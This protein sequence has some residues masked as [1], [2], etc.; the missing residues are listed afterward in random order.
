MRS[1]ISFPGKTGLGVFLWCFFFFTPAIVFS[2]SVIRGTI[3][4]RDGLPLGGATIKINNSSSTTLAD[5]A[6]LFS[7][8]ANTGDVMEVSFVGYR[9]HKVV[10]GN[11]TEL[12][13]ATYHGNHKPGR[14][15]ISGV[16][17]LKEKR[18]YGRC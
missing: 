13:I 17:N 11:E 9:T 12:N 5:S 3:T 8:R 18:Y 6:G 10:L 1:F 2:Q 7:L 16:W 14:G 15:N 4:G